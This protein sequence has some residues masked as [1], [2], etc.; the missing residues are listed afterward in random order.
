ME[1][2]PLGK[3]D[4]WPGAAAA[5]D[6]LS[7]DTA[8]RAGLALV[9]VLAGLLVGVRLGAAPL[10]D[11]DEARH[12][13]TA[14]E[15]LE[16]GAWVEPTLNLEPYR[17]K[18]SGFYVLVGLCYRAF[19]VNE[20]AARTV[21]AVSAWF[22]LLAVYWFGSRRGVMRGL[23]AALLLGACGFFVL[24]GRFTTFDGLFTCLVSTAALSFA[25]WLDGGARSRLRAS[26]VL[27]GLAVLTKGPVAIILVGVPALTA[28]VLT[29]RRLGDTE[30]VRGAIIV[31]GITA[32]WFLPTWIASPDYIVEFLAVH[33]FQRFLGGSSIFHPE[34]AWFFLPILA[35]ALLPWSLHVPRAC[36]A[37]LRSTAPARRFLV[38]YALWV[39]IFFSLSRGKLATYVLPAFPAF[40]VLT[41]WWV[42]GPD[43]QR[44]QR[45]PREGRVV[46]RVAAGV[47]LAT[48]PTALG[49]I[50]WFAPGE[51]AVALLFAPASLAGLFVLMR[52]GTLRSTAHGMASLAAG[53]ALT[54]LAVNVFAAPALGR[55]A[56]D[57]DLARASLDLGPAVRTIS[58]R[59]Q[60]YSFL[61]YARRPLEIFYGKRT[62]RELGGLDGALLLS[63]HRRLVDLE[64]V[65]DT[66]EV[67][68]IAENSRH[69]L[70]RLRRVPARSRAR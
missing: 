52:T 45:D 65:L 19:G 63:K 24:V 32:A 23:L 28:I 5:G 2:T 21:P 29:G 16:R 42:P 55:Y 60:P 37:A 35:A 43:E 56:S 13:L 69:L 10:L 11:P 54:V 30:P 47:A 46:L 4:P 38:L 3:P 34:P 48:A 66:Y 33:N 17:H 27:T 57:R 18:L 67:E 26:Y 49:L 50:A 51:V 6:R 64:S 9:A 22:T 36:A 44:E 61:F 59:V 41:A 39:P 8:R 1:A 40:A 62:E 12:A 15:M 20:A 31:T 25:A 68:P 7:A 14:L 70:I 58:Y 53:A